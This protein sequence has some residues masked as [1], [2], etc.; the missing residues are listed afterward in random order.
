M[1]AIP[2][3]NA[4]GVIALRYRCVEEH[5][6]K[7]LGHS[8]Y[9]REP[10]DD[11]KIYNILTLTMAVPRIA[12][13]EGEIDTITAWQCGI[14]SIGVAGAT[15]WPPIFNRLIRGYQVVT[16][17]DGDP[18]G[19][20]LADTITEKNETAELAQMPEKMDTN[21]YFMTYGPEKLRQKAG[22]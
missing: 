14:P 12:I 21:E 18:A 4:Q 11:A 17:A 13:C 22:F 8:K 20:M 10:G 9:T 3:I 7:D 1:L 2:Y 16:L 6:C 5:E 15:N 19:L